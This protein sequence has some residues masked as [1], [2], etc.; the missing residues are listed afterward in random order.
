MTSLLPLERGRRP[1]CFRC[2]RE[3][4]D[5]LDG[6]LDTGQRKESLPTNAVNPFTH[7][8]VLMSMARPGLNNIAHCIGYFRPAR[9]IIGQKWDHQAR[10][11]WRSPGAGY[12]T[13]HPDRNA[14]ADRVSDRHSGAHGIAVA[15]VHAFCFVDYQGLVFWVGPDGAGWAGCDHVRNFALGADK[16]IVDFGRFAV[17]A[18]D[19]DI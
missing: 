1:E 6:E 8:L 3:V 4:V 11:F 10:E 15:A 7:A 5:E 16:I 9:R 12:L 19:G 2:Q 17:D 13:A 18:Q 14:V